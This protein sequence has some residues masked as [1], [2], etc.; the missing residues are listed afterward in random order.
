MY[1]R[2]SKK[3]SE[4]E[5]LFN[6]IIG[7]GESS[8]VKSYYP[9]LRRKLNELEKFRF[10]M[11]GIDDF[12]AVFDINKD[13]VLVDSNKSFNA[14]INISDFPSPEIFLKDILK[15]SKDNELNRFDPEIMDD[16]NMQIGSITN[17]AGE[18]VSV[19]F[20]LNSL[21]AENKKYVVFIGRDITERIRKEDMLEKLNKML[22]KKLDSVIQEKLASQDLLIKQSRMAAM[23]EMIGN[24]AHQWRQP[25]CSL[26]LLIEDILDA[27][28]SG[29]LDRKYLTDLTENALGQIMFM[30]QTIDNFR[31]YYRP[32]KEK[33]YFCVS[34]SI[35]ET[36]SII[37]KQFKAKNIELK[38]NLLD[39]ENRC[40]LVYGFPNEFK[41][42]I[43]N[44]LMNSMDAVDELMADDSS[45]NGIVKINVTESDSS[46]YVDFIDNGGGVDEDVI[47]KIFE[48]YFT[49]K[50]QDTGTGLGL[51][52]SKMIVENNMKGSLTVVNMDQ[53]ACFTI[54]LP[55]PDKELL[56]NTEGETDN[57]GEAI[58][59]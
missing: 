20:L 27:Y 5:E 10:F 49:T 19:E 28:D 33:L 4:K 6:K 44:L 46:F 1:D 52:M 51:Y 40:H 29:E 42:V 22:E 9:E 36:V 57:F 56:D 37:E 53:C 25:L 48:P 24:I 17:S 34:D 11:D 38:L 50:H 13:Y 32:N 30:T 7:L 59:L 35:R 39:E 23:G 2:S 12:I 8:P 26:G 45:F 31:N 15:I 58:D 14:A 55:K 43:L 47:D 16:N 54:K 21:E 18:A 3:P 41:Q